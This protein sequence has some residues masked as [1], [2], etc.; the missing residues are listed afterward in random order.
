MGEDSATHSARILSLG[1]QNSDQPK[2]VNLLKPR[3]RDTP[4]TLK[5]RASNAKLTE[6][7]VLDRE[8]A[9]E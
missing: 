1:P 5:P 7:L 6:D 9:D 3:R 2:L 8:G 4:R